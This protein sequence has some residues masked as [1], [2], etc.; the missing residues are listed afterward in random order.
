MLIVNLTTSDPAGAIIRQAQAINRYTEHTARVICSRDLGFGWDKD[1][2]LIGEPCAV[3]RVA[4]L[5]RDADIIILH[6]PTELN[7]IDTVSGITLL[8]FGLK[9]GKKFAIYHHGEASFRKDPQAVAD[10]QANIEGPRIVVTPD[11]LEKSPG[12][13]FVPN[14]IDAYDMRYLPSPKVNSGIPEISQCNTFN[15]EKDTDFIKDSLE[16]TP[17]CKFKL[18]SNRT[19]PDCL[20]EKKLSDI[21]IDHLQGY[22]GLSGLEYAAMGV[23]CISGIDSFNAAHIRKFFKTESIPFVQVTRETFLPKLRNLL[24]NEE[25][26]RG[27]GEYHRELMLHIWRPAYIAEKITEIYQDW[28]DNG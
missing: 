22:W 26:R 19:W 8:D 4:S 12:S 13:V 10:F 1:D 5:L 24:N 14:T 6:K 16:Q 2:F 23:P 7:N 28:V 21:G 18:I 9:L 25:M 3:S 17:Q 20:R 27:M 11:L 15:W